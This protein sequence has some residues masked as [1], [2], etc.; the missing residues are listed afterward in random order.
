MQGVARKFLH[1]GCHLFLVW[2]GARPVTGDHTT[3]MGQMPTHAHTMVAGWL[4]SAVFA[5]FYHL[6]P[7]VGGK[8]K[9]CRRCI[10]G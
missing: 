4:M 5:F 9:K 2:H 1:P 3:I 8:N 6:F 10:S 7:A